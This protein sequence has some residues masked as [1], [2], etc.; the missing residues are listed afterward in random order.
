MKKHLLVLAVTPIALSGV[1]SGALFTSN[2]AQA[3]GYISKPESRNYLC[4][5]GE[6]SQCGN[7]VF[8]PQSVEGPD[9]F[10]QSGPADGTLASAGISAFSQLNAQSVNRWAKRHIKAGANQFSWTFTA[11]HV[12]QDWRY[13]ITKKNWNPNAP[14]TRDQLETKPFCSVDGQLRPP[15]RQVTHV[16]NVP[17]D[18][19]G[20]H[21]VLG[22][23]D[24]G[25]T[26]MSFYNAV[27]LMIDNGNNSA[28]VW[29]DV[30]DV[31]TSRT[32]NVGDK[33]QTRVFSSTGEISSLNTEIDIVSP[34]Q[35]AAKAWPLLLAKKVNDSQSWLQIG[36]LGADNK[37]IPIAGKNEIYAQQAAGISRVEIAFSQAP[38]PQPYFAVNGVQSRYQL[39]KTGSIEISFNLDISL[40]ANVDVALNKG[41]E[42][43][44][45]QSY[46]VNAGLSSHS[47]Q[48]NDAKPGHYS[49]V[50][51]YQTE[52]GAQGQ[53]MFHL[54]IVA[55]DHVT[56]PDPVKPPVT[57]T[58]QFVFPEH[59]AH[60]AAGTKV[61]QAKTGKVYQCKPWPNNG[62]CVQW[63]KGSNQFEPGVGSAWTMAWT[64][65]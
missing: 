55:A 38:A 62:Y 53:K 26:G 7:I 32:L 24:V 12:T 15:A 34:E 21:I 17:A 49:F 50:V 65:L 4:R 11:Q 57:G 14:L 9:R 27:D 59:L 25:D 16:C 41:Y 64:E 3:H 39:S 23:W 8:E 31:F 47:L 33:V 19:S 37:I 48:L 1:L 5:I 45:A 56:P 30:G 6:N 61:F 43:A 2:V 35:G 63:S 28:L 10:P 58:Y 42:T 29:Q 54:D 52:K 13:F 46:R 18:R 44:A 22:V 60:Y 20:Y 36:V 51:N 40:A